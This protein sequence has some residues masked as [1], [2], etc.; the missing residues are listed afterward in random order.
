[1]NPKP[2]LN[3]S[4]KQLRPYGAISPL[5]LLGSFWGSAMTS[6]N[7]TSS[8]EEFEV[9]AV[10]DKSC[11]LLSRQTSLKH[12]L[13][14]MSLPR[15]V[16]QVLSTPTVFQLIKEFD[17]ICHGIG[18]H[19]DVTV[20][21]PMD[22][23]VKP[24]SCPPG[25]V[26]IHLLPALQTELERLQAEGVVEDVPVDDN[27]QWV[28]RIVPVPRKIEGSSTPGIRLTID[29]RNVNKGLK[30]VHHHMPTVEQLRYDLNG[31][32]LFSHLD[33]RDAF[34]QLQLD[35]DSKKL[36]TFATP[37]GLKRLTRL[38]QGATPS[39]AIFHETL[40]RDLQGLPNVL[41]IADNVI[42]WGCGS[43]RTEA[44]LSHLNALRQVFE[45]F[46]RK[47][48][49]IN[50]PKCIFEADS[51]SFFGYIF[52]KDGVSP[53]P[54]KV[55]ALKEASAPASK[56][57]VRSFLGMAGFNQQFIPSFATISEPLR[58][59]ITK[60]TAFV[61]GP[62]QQRSFHDI[63]HALI[64]TALLAFFDPRKKTS[65]FTDASP[66][67]VNAVLAQDDGGGVLRPV[68]FASRSLSTTETGYS[69]IEREALAMQF[70][71]HRYQ[72]FL[73]GAPFTHYIDPETLKPMIENPRKDAPARIERL[74]L[75]LQGFQSSIKLIKGSK[76]PA[77]YLSRHPLP[78]NL[79]STEEIREYADIENHVFMVIQ[80][81]PNA[82]TRD[83]ILAELPN[84]PQLS[85]VKRLLQANTDVSRLLHSAKVTIQPFIPIWNELSIGKGLILRGERIILPRALIP[86]AIQLSHAGHMGIQKSKAFL[87]A[88]LWFPGM[89]AL[90][91]ER[92]KQCVSCQAAVPL[93]VKQPLTMSDIP[94]EPWQ[95]VAADLFGP[96]P[97]GEKILVLKC[98]RSK[99]PEIRVFLRNQTTDAEKIVL[100]MEKMFIIHGIPDEIL[101]DNGPPFNSKA[102]SSF[103][104][105]AGF[106]HRKITPLW[107]QANGQAEAFMKNL[108]KSIRIAVSQKQDW[109]H[110][111][112]EF[113][114]AYR[115]TPHPATGVSPASLMYPGRRYKTKLPPSTDFRSTEEI[116][117]S[118]RTNAEKAKAYTDTR[119][120]AK[121]TSLALGDRVLV[122]QTKHNKFSLPYNPK[123][124]TV[125]TMKGSMI[126][127]RTDDHVITRNISFFKPL[128]GLPSQNPKKEGPLTATL[129]PLSHTKKPVVV[130]CNT[131]TTEANL[132][133]QNGDASVLAAPQDVATPT[134]VETAQEVELPMKLIPRFPDPPEIP[135]SDFTLPSDVRLS[136]R[137]G[138]ER[139]PPRKPNL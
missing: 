124:Y 43:N 53:D 137:A 90:A 27:N 15:A 83:R 11:C 79:C 56:E 103:S 33:L 78:L 2:S 64:Q 113:L 80:S 127:A 94:A 3:R 65:L 69:Q 115:A 119:R 25:R 99:W 52:S 73:R 105:R 76:N 55:R 60:N 51:I 66:V 61:W 7:I 49:T 85:E 34:S 101:T 110:N 38:V 132:P 129:K 59:L 28:S 4:F 39:S 138:R 58:R 6:P 88:S 121:E 45:L 71:C 63:K 46:R 106:H 40:R 62:E 14:E 30:Q 18:C 89:D 23:N 42:V 100:A 5:K 122:K 44:Q 35:E 1:M 81:L 70:G 26:P 93:N 41:N 68:S 20:S 112:D 24:V 50:K 12:G 96:L 98:L 87:R 84:D 102:F 48:L 29:W 54:E 118:F 22:D 13:I 117:T 131:P 75:K 95:T 139:K 120:N 16:N 31:A 17:D 72:L 10:P 67:G 136:S 9:A 108:G 116:E 74:R 32:Q 133:P 107:P 111:L 36:T 77:D 92:V 104:N 91:E 21:L 114:M 86:D 37:W 109:Q 126:T 19:K 123:P 135:T 47:G 125:I 128:P 82:I 130:I 97:T 8:L 57:E 134:G